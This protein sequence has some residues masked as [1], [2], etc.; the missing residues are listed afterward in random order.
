MAVRVPY[1]SS[2]AAMQSPDRSAV[3]L[4]SEPICAKLT[5]NHVR[6]RRDALEQLGKHRSFRGLQL[7]L[8]RQICNSRRNN[9]K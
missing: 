3:Y 7:L 6:L 5:I 2:N 4:L 9:E 8:V 1:E